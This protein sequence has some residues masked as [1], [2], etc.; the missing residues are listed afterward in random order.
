MHFLRCARTCVSPIFASLAILL[1]CSGS[2]IGSTISV[3]NGSFESPEAPRQDPFA[4]PDIDY[5][6]KSAQPAW[7]YPS[8]NFDTPWDYLMGQFFNVPFPGS[9]IENCDGSQAAFLF[10]SQE[11]ALFQDYD[12]IY[13]TNTAPTH[14]FNAIYHPGS[15]YDLTIGVIGGGGGMTN[16]TT[17]QVSLYYRDA[18]SNKV[19]VASTSITHSVDLFP[20][21]TQLVDFQ[22][23]LPEV[24][25]GDPWAG[26][27]IGIQ[28]L[29]TSMGLAP[30]YW[31]LDNVR[32]TETPLLLLSSPTVTNSQ[33]SFSISS[34]PGV[35]FEVLASTN[36]AAIPANWI[37]LGSFTNLTGVTVFSDTTTNSNRRYYRA[38]QL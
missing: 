15:S 24:K 17:L 20:T 8:N 38:R 16:G 5:W 37:S 2:S 21:N 22:V 14:A 32:L 10:A 30:G 19:T 28:C 34:V 26:K 4:G 3:P 31:D 7:Y 23:H 1:I 18:A 29:S 27:N 25:P 6:Q 13:G 35:Q 33:I 12:T 36:V 9:F 11:A